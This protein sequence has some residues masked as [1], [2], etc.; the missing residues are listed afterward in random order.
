MKQ[1][2]ICYAH[3]QNNN[4]DDSSSPYILLRNVP[5]FLTNVERNDVENMCNEEE[6]SA[7]DKGLG[8]VGHEQNIAN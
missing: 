8:L 2:Y 7:N 5:D 3:H 1:K 4:I 6:P